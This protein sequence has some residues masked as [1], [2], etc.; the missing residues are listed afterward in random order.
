MV[1]K[2]AKKKGLIPKS[3]RRKLSAEP[4]E[5]YHAVRTPKRKRSVGCQ[6]DGDEDDVPSDHIIQQLQ[7][8]ANTYKQKYE[9]VKKQYEALKT[10]HNVYLMHQSAKL[11]HNEAC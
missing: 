9:M 7:E 2:I 1:R 5:S 4:S 3:R 10:Q 6:S 11:T 8:V